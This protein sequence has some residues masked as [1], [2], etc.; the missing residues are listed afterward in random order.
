M[1]NSALNRWQIFGCLALVVGLL[2]FTTEPVSAA[3]TGPETQLLLDMDDGPNSVRVEKVGR[4]C[5]IG[6][7][8]T[9]TQTGFNVVIGATGP[10]SRLSLFG[11]TDIPTDYRTKMRVNIALHNRT[12]GLKASFDKLPY[13]GGLFLYQTEM[14]NIGADHTALL[15]LRGLALSAQ[16]DDSNILRVS[17]GGAN[18]VRAVKEFNQCLATLPSYWTFP[19]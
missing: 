4:R 17:I 1:G 2:P 5:S 6:T 7:F 15:H 18:Y 12:A 14:G 19:K 13:G 9:Q 8:N 11:P 16:G 3:Q 10:S